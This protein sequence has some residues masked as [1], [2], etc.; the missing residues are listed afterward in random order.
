MAVN[1]HFASFSAIHKREADRTRAIRI[2][3]SR[4]RWFTEYE[5]SP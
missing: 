2:P 1:G 4:V 5:T 3:I